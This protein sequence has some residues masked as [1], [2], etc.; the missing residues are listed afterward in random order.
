MALEHRLELRLLQKLILTPQLQQAIKLLQMPQ[1]E[2]SQ[3]LTLELTENPFLEDI[4]EEPSHEELTQIEKQE[5]ESFDEAK[6]DSELPLEKLMS[7]SVDEYFEERSSDGRDLGY[8]NPGT[9]VAPSFEQFVSKAADLYEHLRWQLGL[10]DASGDVKAAAEAVIGNIDENGYLDATDEELAGQ[11]GMS[12]ETARTAVKLIQTFDPPGIGARDLKECLILQ[13]EPLKLRGTI[14]ESL[15]TNDLDAI[16]KKKY[17]QLAKQYN[18]DMDGILAAVKVIEGL[19]PKPCRNFSSASPIYI[20]PDV[21]VVKTEGK[22]NIIL[23]DEGMPRL[24]VSNYYKKLLSQKNSLPKEERQ[25]MEEKL[26]SAVWLL[27]SL[28]QRNKTIYRITEHLLRL[29]GEFFDKGIQHLRP[30]NLKDI[31]TEIEM[32]ESTVSRATSNKYLSCSHGIFNFRFFFSSGIQ[33]GETGTVSST[34]VK[35]LI[36]KLV[37][38]EDT[39][40]PLNDQKIVELLKAQDITIA[41]RT[42]AKYREE[43]NIS[44]VTQRK[45]FD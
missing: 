40:K 23:N 38:E 28:D 26:R 22:Y 2:L 11:S 7:F 12:I 9:V 41:R 20:A 34:S 39:M 14:V 36:K 42:V 3:T 15:I 44:P 24:R 16:A 45:R 4:T 13:L 31:A 27:K 18:T 33:G 29:Q 1:L 8:F 37:S 6:D 21:Y 19:E 32:H 35:D 25:F 43:L 17:H 30:L 5:E 10:S